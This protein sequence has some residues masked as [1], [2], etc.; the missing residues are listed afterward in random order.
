MKV[1]Q[2]NAFCYRQMHS[3]ITSSGVL[4]YYTYRRGLRWQMPSSILVT[5]NASH[6]FQLTDVFH[7]KNR[8]SSLYYQAISSYEDWK[9]AWYRQG[10]TCMLH[11][12]FT[13]LYL[14]FGKSLC[15]KVSGT[16]AGY[17]RWVTRTLDAWLIP[18]ATVSHG[19]TTRSDQARGRQPIYCQASHMHIRA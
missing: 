6:E 9:S 17:W 16:L 10:A 1:I 11:V 4:V 14:V 8:R 3:Y 18:V 13:V 12:R 2:R 5:R 7:D 19:T 15:R